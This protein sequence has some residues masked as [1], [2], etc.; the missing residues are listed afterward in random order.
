MTITVFVSVIGHAVEDGIY[1]YLLPLPLCP[2]RAAQVVLVLYLVR[3][4]KRSL[5]KGL[6]H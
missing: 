5:L 1:K 3:W 6:G 2:Q 4:P